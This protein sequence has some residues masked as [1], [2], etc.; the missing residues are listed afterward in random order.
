MFRLLFSTQ[1]DATRLAAVVFFGTRIFTDFH[2][3]PYL[4]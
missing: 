1:T 2:G 3:F 4:C